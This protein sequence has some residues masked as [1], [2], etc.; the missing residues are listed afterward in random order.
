M[1]KFVIDEAKPK[2]VQAEI[3]EICMNLLQ[4]EWFTSKM[5]GLDI[6]LFMI[7]KDIKEV[8]R[9]KLI[10]QVVETSRDKVYIVRKAV[11]VSLPQIINLIPIFPI[12]SVTLIV[13]ELIT[14][15]AEVVKTSSLEGALQYIEQVKDNEDILVSLFPYFLDGYTDGFWMVRKLYMENTKKIFSL[16]GEIK[17]TRDQ[18]LIPIISR[19]IIQFWTKTSNPLSQSKILI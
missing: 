12:E 1:F 4:G 9:Q 18:V 11:A 2:Q 17:I 15:V 6:A 16:F 14:D 7:S 3:L 19:S 10:K 13:K 5:S 8:N